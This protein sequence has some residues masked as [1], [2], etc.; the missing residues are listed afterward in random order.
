MAV[1]PNPIPVAAARVVRARLGR[2]LCALVLPFALAACA[3]FT[4]PTKAKGETTDIRALRHQFNEFVALRKFGGLGGLVSEDVQLIEPA[5][6]TSGR[7]NL[8]RA[9]EALVQKRPDLLLDFTPDAVERNP[10]WAFAAERGRWSQ[11]WQEQGEPV[12]VRG[13][14]YALWKRRDG[15]WRIDA[16]VMTPVS[17]KGARYC[18]SQE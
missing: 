4:W 9:Y 2:L 14:Y 3:H 17:C 13:T 15:R 10:R 8:V 7:K 16:Q 11:S 18:K 1:V 6:T 5:R 12:E